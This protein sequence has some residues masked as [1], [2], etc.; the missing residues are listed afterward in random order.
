MLTYLLYISKLNAVNI[1]EKFKQLP[2]STQR[3]MGFGTVLALFVALPLFL[4]AVLNGNFELRRKATSGEPTPSPITSPAPSDTPG[5]TAQPPTVS[6]VPSN[7]SGYPG[8]TL[9][10][11][12][13][14]TNNNSPECLATDFSIFTYY[15]P[16]SYTHFSGSGV[17]P[18]ILTLES[19]QTGTASFYLTSSL[20]DTAPGTYT[21]GV[22]IVGFNHPVEYVVLPTTSPSPSV[23]P[24]PSPSNPCNNSDINKDGITDITDYSIFV[25]DFFK[26]P[27]TNPRSDMN[28]DG[29]VDI[30]DYSIL[31]SKFLVQT[32]ACQ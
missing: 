31:V 4:Y 14:V 12:I 18:Q 6:I 16:G 22:S 13:G 32:G 27:P 7:Q 19:G 10:Y 30:T 23:S 28:N 20:I 1:I 29:I 9:T 3:L 25:S 26:S 24:S 5:C 2:I 17:N 21:A 15:D 8:D 11:P